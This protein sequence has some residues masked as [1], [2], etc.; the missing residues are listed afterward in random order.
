MLTKLKLICVLA[1]LSLACLLPKASAQQPPPAV[2]TVHPGAT[3]SYD[4]K[5]DGPDSSEITGV[6]VSLNYWGGG[7]INQPN[8][9]I[10]STSRQFN[11]A[12]DGVFHVSWKLLDSL[13]TGDYEV[14]VTALTADNKLQYIYTF[15]DTGLPLVHFDN[16]RQ[17]Q[18]PQITVTQKSS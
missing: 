10:T 4:V 12:P 9:A 11:R 1:S 14:I 2:G 15:V 7:G 5:L 16:S 13:A 17:F 18:I 8:F 6:I 3:L